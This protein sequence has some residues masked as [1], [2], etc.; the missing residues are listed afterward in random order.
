M[1]DRK[2]KQIA[3]AVKASAVKISRLS[4]QELRLETKRLKQEL[5]EGKSLDEILPEAYAAIAEADR[6]ILGIYPFDEK[7]YGAAAL[8][9]G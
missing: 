4:D 8:H 6:R 1:T 7:I 5:S 9:Q 2:L 3:D